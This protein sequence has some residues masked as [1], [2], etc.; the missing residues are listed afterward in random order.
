M[1]VPPG[2][3]NPATLVERYPCYCVP[4]ALMALSGRRQG[5]VE[6]AVIATLG[7]RENGDPVEG[8][9]GLSTVGAADR[10]GLR[11]RDVGGRYGLPGARITLAD[12]ILRRVGTDPESTL[13]VGAGGHATLVSGDVVC[14]ARIGGWAPVSAIPEPAAIVCSV[15]RFDPSGGMLTMAEAVSGAETLMRTWLLPV[16]PGQRGSY[17]PNQRGRV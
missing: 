11:L 12:L 16:A 14:C 10:L 15:F 4:W 9:G 5:E 17:G 7:N 1:I 2:L 8:V 3:H 13:L 6:A